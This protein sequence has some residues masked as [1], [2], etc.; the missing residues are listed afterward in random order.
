MP[1]KYFL[2]QMPTGDTDSGPDG[3]SEYDG[4]IWAIDPDIPV[5]QGVNPVELLH[6]PNEDDAV[7]LVD[8]LERR[9]RLGVA[10]AQ[11]LTFI[12]SLRVPQNQ[13]EAVAQIYGGKQV[14]DQL[15]E[16]LGK[17]G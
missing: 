9:D 14:M 15:R 13:A 1:W 16:A 11:A 12:E 5:D 4:W 6:V 17:T 8:V 7:R 3:G 2:G 10:C